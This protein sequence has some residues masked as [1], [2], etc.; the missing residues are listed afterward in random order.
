MKLNIKDRIYFPQLLPQNNSY[1]DF[2]LKK[3][4]LAK[5]ALTGKDKEIYNIQENQ[6]ER[7]ITWD[8]KKDHEEPLEVEFSKEELTYLRKACEGLSDTAY[9][10]D[11]WS[12]VEKIYENNGQE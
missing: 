10:D 3:S 12:V 7:S 4:I 5:V 9:P 2:N 8:S 11:F 1:M 6:D